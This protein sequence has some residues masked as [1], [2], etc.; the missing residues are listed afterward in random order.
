MRNW[1]RLLQ[2][3]Q[4][5][6]HCTPEKFL[7]VFLRDPVLD[8]SISIAVSRTREKG[9]TATQAAK[10]ASGD[11]VSVAATKYEEEQFKEQRVHQQGVVNVRGLV[12]AFSGYRGSG[13]RWSLRLMKLLLFRQ[14]NL[15]PSPGVALTST[16]EQYLQSIRT[17]DSIATNA[18]G[19]GHRSF[20][21]N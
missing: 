3:L 20:N 2:F 10:K 11:G 19:G 12:N 1:F 17:S 13:S 9:K 16:P 5:R 15:S 6:L 7:F 14:S 8:H 18:T 4:R 21:G